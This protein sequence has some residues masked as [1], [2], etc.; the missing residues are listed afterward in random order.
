MSA[1]PLV[2]VGLEAAETAPGV[3]V[4]LFVLVYLA[5]TLS[6]CFVTPMTVARELGGRL[7]AGIFLRQAG[8]SLAGAVLLAAPLTLFES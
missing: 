5:S 2:L 7:A 6:A 1:N 4:R 8:T 3:A